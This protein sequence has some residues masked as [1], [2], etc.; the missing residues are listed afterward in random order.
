MNDTAASVAASTA[1]RMLGGLPQRLV[2]DGLLDE[3]TMMEAVASARE[4]K[5]NVVSWL[6]SQNLASAREIAIAAAH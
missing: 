3:P 4:H 2:Q 1:T 5:V 6:V